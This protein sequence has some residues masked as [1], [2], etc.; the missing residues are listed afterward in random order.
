MKIALVCP[1]DFSQPG[2]VQSHIRDLAQVLRDRHHIVKIITPKTTNS[3]EAS[4]Q[5]IYVGKSYRI[6]FQGT[7]ID[8]SLAMGDDYQYLQEILEREKFDIIHYHTIWNPFLSLQILCLSKA[9]NIATFHDTP[10][11][12][13]FGKIANSILMPTVSHWLIK[14]YLKAAI[15]VSEVPARYLKKSFSERVYIIPNGIFYD[16]FCNNLP[17]TQYRD[18]KFNILFLGRLE[19]RKG[20]FYLLEAFAILKQEFPKIRLLIAG[21]GYQKP[22]IDRFIIQHHL[23]DAILL[24]FISEED[25]PKYYA[26]CDL[27]CSPAPYGES[28][29]LVLVEAMAS[30][31]PAIGAAN[32]GYKTVLTGKGKQLLFKPQSVKALV[33]KLKQLIENPSLRAE[34][35]AWGK[36]EAQQ[37]DWQFI[38]QKIEQVYQTA[39]SQNP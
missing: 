34:L 30:C 7:Q 32:L 1:Y 22:A 18:N 15:A 26:T 29:G 24:N 6:K 3:Q 25:K 4:S 35:A 28:F 13:V 38:V 14:Y 27:Y 10:R 5:V 12:T 37:Y 33:E 16:R 8:L 39:L 21:D 11:E 17:V 9:A 2:G 20:I 19:N 31:K 36:V 23:E